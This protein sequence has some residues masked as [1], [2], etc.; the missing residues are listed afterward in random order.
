[1][2]R[3]QQGKSGGS[4]GG[5]GGLFNSLFTSGG[6]DIT[7]RSFENARLGLAGT[8]SSGGADEAFRAYMEHG[9]EGREIL[10]YIKSVPE[11][12]RP[13][14]IQ[15]IKIMCEAAEAGVLSADDTEIIKEWIE[16]IRRVL[17]GL[18]KII[19]EIVS[20]LSGLDAAPD[21]LKSIQE[22]RDKFMKTLGF[23]SQAVILSE[24]VSD[25]TE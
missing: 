16:S 12:D 3:K 7:R 9:K 21:M 19:V 23:L 11:G 18:D 2:G 10:D 1:M 17:D 5:L 20:G 4:D 15:K 14:I 13:R 22:S 25:A 6:P 8:H 24:E